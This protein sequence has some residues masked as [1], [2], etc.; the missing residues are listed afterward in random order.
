MCGGLGLE[1]GE[2]EE[3]FGEQGETVRKL[4]GARIALL[5]YTSNF[6]EQGDGTY[7]RVNFVPPKPG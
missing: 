4:A 3:V 2:G 5:S 7:Y 1:R 6:P